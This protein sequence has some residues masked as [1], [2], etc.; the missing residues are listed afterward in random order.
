MLISVC[1]LFCEAVNVIVLLSDINIVSKGMFLIELSDTLQLSE[2]ITLGV[3]VCTNDQH[4]SINDH[5]H[6]IRYIMLRKI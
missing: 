1:V 4:F 2:N 6:S 3:C 5:S